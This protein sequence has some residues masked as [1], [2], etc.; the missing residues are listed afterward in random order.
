MSTRITAQN[1]FFNLRIFDNHNILNNYVTVAQVELD[2][3][4]DALVICEQSIFIQF[5]ISNI[6]GIPHAPI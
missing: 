5:L 3:E 2:L 4:I 6:G 1:V